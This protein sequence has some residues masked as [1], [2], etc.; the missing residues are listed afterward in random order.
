MKRSTADVSASGLPPFSN[1][2]EAALAILC[3]QGR[4]SVKAAG[5]LGQMTITRGALTEK[6]LNWFQHLLEDSG[7]PPLDEEAEAGSN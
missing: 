5:F 1:R 2:R 3:G 7:L 6:Q 4:L